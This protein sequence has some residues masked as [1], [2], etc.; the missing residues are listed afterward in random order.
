MSYGH[1][2]AHCC[3]ISL[4]NPGQSARAVDAVCCRHGC[5]AGQPEYG[6][7]AHPGRPLSRCRCVSVHI[8]GLLQAVLVFKAVEGAPHWCSG[9]MLV[10]G[11][12]WRGNDEGQ[13]TAAST[14]AFKSSNETSE[15]D[16]G[17][18]K[19]LRSLGE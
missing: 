5:A 19:G 13:L 15:D 6:P 9:L 3:S 12:G 8:L 11:H 14:I 18:D 4:S 2:E 1:D 7:S 10:R 16:D 17:H